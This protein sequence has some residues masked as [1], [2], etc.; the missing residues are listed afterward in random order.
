VWERVGSPKTRHAQFPPVILFAEN[1]FK[2]LGSRYSEATP[3]RRI[4]GK[5]GG[6]ATFVRL[7][8]LGES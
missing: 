5:V 6:R 7:V 2:E 3:R 4:T 8:A 1:N